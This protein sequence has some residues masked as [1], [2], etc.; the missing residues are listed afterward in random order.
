MVD[1]LFVAGNAVPTVSAGILEML[2]DDGP[3]PPYVFGDREPA[4]ENLRA[5]HPASR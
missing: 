1:R 2:T 3:R 5:A 4:I